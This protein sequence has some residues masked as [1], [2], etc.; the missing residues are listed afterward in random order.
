MGWPN[1][2]PHEIYDKHMVNQPTVS[3]IDLLHVYIAIIAKRTTKI[4]ITI[5]GDFE[6]EEP[7]LEVH[8][9]WWQDGKLEG[10]VGVDLP[11]VP[12]QI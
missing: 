11:V 6:G 4:P 10:T 12:G 2:S 8:G 7:Y 5:K 3:L 1:T 9:H